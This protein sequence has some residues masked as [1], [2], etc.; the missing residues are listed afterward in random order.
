LKD[1][2]C[3]LQVCKTLEMLSCS[4]ELQ[5]TANFN[6]NH[7]INKRGLYGKKMCFR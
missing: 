3:M 2:L 7:I 4:Q 1:L 6:F 5:T